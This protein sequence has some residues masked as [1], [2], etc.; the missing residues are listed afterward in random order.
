MNDLMKEMEIYAAE[1]DI[2]IMQ[3]EGIEFFK[4]LVKEN[5]IYSIL[6]IGSA[7]GYS[8]ICLASLDPKIHILTIE[9]DDER[10]QKAVENIEKSGLKSQ[11]E[12]LHA[13]ALECEIEG[14]FDCIFIDAAKA[15]YIRFFE[16]YEKNLKDTGIIVSDNLSFHG[17]VEHPTDS[18]SRNLKQLVRKIRNYIDYLKNNEKYDTLFLN[19]GDGLAISRKKKTNVIE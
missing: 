10:Y 9:R 13:D 6:E 12:I 19:K 3:K 11:I 16:K 18:M 4:E 8:A 1:Y 2:P 17:Y 5:E 7:I 15:Q 14:L